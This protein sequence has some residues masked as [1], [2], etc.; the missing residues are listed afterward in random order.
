VLALFKD[1]GAHSLRPNLRS[2][3]MIIENA[4][5]SGNWNDIIDVGVANAK[6]VITAV[7]VAT[8]TTITTA[9]ASASASAPTASSASYVEDDAVDRSAATCR[10][11]SAVQKHAESQRDHIITTLNSLRVNDGQYIA[12]TENTKM[13]ASGN[14]KTVKPSILNFSLPVKLE[15]LQKK[16]NQ[17][18][19][20]SLI[21]NLGMARLLRTSFRQCASN[22]QEVLHTKNRTL[23]GRLTVRYR[24]IMVENLNKAAKIYE[25]LCILDIHATKQD[26]ETLLS[27][28]LWFI[29]EPLTTLSDKLD[30]FLIAAKIATRTLAKNATF[31]YELIRR[32]L[33]CFMDHIQ[34]ESDTIATGAATAD[35][36]VGIEGNNDSK[37]NVEDDVEVVKLQSIL[38][39]F[40]K[41]ATVDPLLTRVLIPCQIKFVLKFL[42]SQNR[43]GRVVDFS[44]KLLCN[45]QDSISYAF[46]INHGMWKTYVNSISHKLA[47]APRYQR[48]P[49][50][51]TETNLSGDK[52]KDPVSKSKEREKEKEKIVAMRT[53]VGTIGA[54]SDL[55]VPREVVLQQLRNCI[56][57]VQKHGLLCERNFDLYLLELL[58]GQRVPDSVLLYVR[59]A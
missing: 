33:T 26:E 41:P 57:A 36:T 10:S 40:L 23:H 48:L 20:Y 44:H 5:V 12:G 18:C 50:V 54:I 22:I 3:N 2:V 24:E 49:V 35:G 8:N 6:A 13:S 25:A 32:L 1:I 58:L 14:I 42:A 19:Q 34:V 39:D 11:S 45:G 38:L 7:A 9:T 59:M 31:D 28:Y 16:I 15:T 55:D 51:G 4:N 37:I 43:H 27:A 52:E 29:G 56:A 47:S 21:D 53:A 17:S 46:I 30:K